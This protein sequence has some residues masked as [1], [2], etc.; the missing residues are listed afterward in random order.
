MSRPRL[1]AR[2]P[3]FE[4]PGASYDIEEQGGVLT[5]TCPSYDF[6]KAKPKACKHLR[7]YHAATVAIER[8]RERHGVTALD[9]GGALCRQ[10]LVALLAATAAKALKMRGGKP[11]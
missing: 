11:Q 3:S 4:R 10:C 1:M 7:V 2:L 8:C 5:C 9:H 6:S